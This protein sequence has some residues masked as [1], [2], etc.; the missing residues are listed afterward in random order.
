VRKFCENSV[1]YPVLNQS[2]GTQK[3]KKGTAISCALFSPSSK[4]QKSHKKSPKKLAFVQFEFLSISSYFYLKKLRIIG[5]H[6]PL[7]SRG[8]G[9]A[10]PREFT[11]ELSRGRSRVILDSDPQFLP[12][13]LR[14]FLR[15]SVPK[16]GAQFSSALCGEKMWRKFIIFCR[17]I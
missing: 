8:Q 11:L 9:V 7:G 5:V 12:L 13:S 6:S 1:R 17:N 3:S 15:F 16:N 14:R 10:T 4:T 2:P